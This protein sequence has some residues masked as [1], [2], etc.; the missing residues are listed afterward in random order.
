MTLSDDDSDKF[1]PVELHFD[2]EALFV[3]TTKTTRMNM[4]TIRTL[5]K[6]CLYVSSQWVHVRS[7]TR[8]VRS[9]DRLRTLSWNPGPLPGDDHSA[10]AHHICGPWHIICLQEGAGFADHPALHH[11]FYVVTAHQSLLGP[12]K[13]LVA[14]AYFRRPVAG[15]LPPLYDPARP[16]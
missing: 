7:A 12:S 3:T 2:T 11:R 9:T 16:R 4:N 14:R 1:K 5:I 6:I 8:G 13:G 10:E 15:G